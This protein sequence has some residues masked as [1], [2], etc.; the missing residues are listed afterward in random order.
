MTVR[1]R[2]PS[3]QPAVPREDGLRDEMWAAYGEIWVAA[4][5]KAVPAKPSVL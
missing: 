3:Q 1:L 5:S 2:P 4:L